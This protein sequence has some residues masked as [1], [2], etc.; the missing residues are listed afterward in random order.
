MEVDVFKRGWG[1]LS[2]LYFFKVKIVTFDVLT[3]K[4]Y[5]KC[6]KKGGIKKSG[7][8]KIKKEGHVR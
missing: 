8:K 3:I 6:L 2:H 4:D 7:G 1:R 5:I